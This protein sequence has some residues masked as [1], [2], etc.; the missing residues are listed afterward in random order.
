[1]FLDP[2]GLESKKKTKNTSTMPS[3]LPWHD[4]EQK[5]CHVGHGCAV[6]RTRCVIPNATH[7]P[8]ISFS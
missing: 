8:T 6:V 5:L 7:F 4:S 2:I 3:F 1:L